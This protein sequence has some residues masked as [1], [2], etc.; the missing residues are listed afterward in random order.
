MDLTWI[1]PLST[2]CYPST[3]LSVKPLGCTTINREKTKQNIIT[4]NHKANRKGMLTLQYGEFLV[5]S[6]TVFPFS[7]LFT[8]YEYSCLYVQ[9]NSSANA[10]CGGVLLREKV[11][12]SLGKIFVASVVPAHTHMHMHARVFSN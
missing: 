11:S 5:V 3:D 2:S 12:V 4:M 9:L 8:V 10:Y 1:D 6:V 7:L